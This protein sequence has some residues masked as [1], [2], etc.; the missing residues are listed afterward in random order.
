MLILTNSYIFIDVYSSVINVEFPFA[1]SCIHH[2]P[3][4]VS[5]KMNLFIPLYFIRP[6]VKMVKSGS[7][8]FPP[9]M[10]KTQINK[11]Q[12]MAHSG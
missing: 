5:S 10:K 1:V 9:V 11:I 8:T 7:D 4:P 2:T 12:Y 6:F 3:F